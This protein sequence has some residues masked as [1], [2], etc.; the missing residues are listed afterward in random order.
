MIQREDECTIIIII[1][2]FPSLYTN[3]WLTKIMHAV[4]IGFYCYFPHWKILF[5][6]AQNLY[7]VSSSLILSS[8]WILESCIKQ[9]LHICSVGNV[10]SRSAYWYSLFTA[11]AHKL[12]K[13]SKSM[14]HPYIHNL[15]R[16][17][18]FSTF[19]LKCKSTEFF[20]LNPCCLPLK[21]TFFYVSETLNVFVHLTHKWNEHSKVRLTKKV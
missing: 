2:I 21:R 18:I 3:H 6:L 15:C 1:I 8:F 14:H 19:C 12:C 16:F 5:L 9:T 4:Y 7:T 13:F 10:H 17:P 20:L 11:W